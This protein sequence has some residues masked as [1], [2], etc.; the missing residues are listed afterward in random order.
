MN[1]FSNI[2]SKP[3]LV[4]GLSFSLFA[5]GGD[6]VEPTSSSSTTAQETPKSDDAIVVAITQDFAP[7]TY[8]DERGDVTGFDI[9]VINAIGKSKGLN[10]RFKTTNFDGVFTEVEQG[11]SDVAITSIFATED[12]AN[13]YSLTNPYYHSSAVYFYRADNPKL[14]NVNL[15]TLND[16]S[17]KGLDLVGT[18]GTKHIERIESVSGTNSIKSVK[19]DFEGFGRVLRKEADVALTDASILAYTSKLHD[20]TGENA[21]KS[22]AYMGEQ[23]YVMVLKKGNTELLQTLNDG[24]NELIQS[25]EINQFKQKYGLE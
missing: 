11:T 5:C 1:L 15:S 21:L 16:L 7:F 10:I 13:Q 8:L 19:S 22:V 6:K 20:A 3:L 4:L 24:I 2:L 14:S 18:A 25:G 9:D 12:R 17:G 23:G